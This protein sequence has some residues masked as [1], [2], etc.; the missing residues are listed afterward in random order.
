M[1]K[2]PTIFILIASA[3]HG[4][5]YVKSIIEENLNK[6]AEEIKFAEKAKEI[7]ATSLKT[8]FINDSMSVDEKIE[9]LNDL[10]DNHMKTKV[11]GDENMRKMLQ[12]LLG[13]VIR[14]INHD[15]HALFALKSI[16][17]KI[18]ESNNPLLICT[19]NRYINEQELMYPINLLEKKEDKIDYIRW[20]IDY[21]KTKLDTDKILKKF[22]ELTKPYIKDSK[23][24]SMINKIKMK[25][26]RENDKLTNTTNSKNDYFE[27][28]KGIDFEKIKEMSK[29]E[30]LS[31]GI[32][33]IFRPLLPENDSYNDLS[34]ED[35]I[36]EVS[37]FNK[38][39]IEDI[40]KI[41]DNY[42]M[43][44]LKFNYKNINKYGY[45]RA[46]PNHY[47]ETALNE[48]KPEAFINYPETHEQNIKND[49]KEFFLKPQI[50][51]QSKI[52]NKMQ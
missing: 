9:V 6:K 50:K 20:A 11:L 19:D 4:K 18:T 1:Q 8:E 13:D 34:K 24:Q 39:S 25:F 28:V 23:D 22:D 14:D 26:I 30:S 29:Q 46:N 51:A 32:V 12:V 31:N 16:E 35:L 49:M 37:K 17:E 5:D 44:D 40:Q 15:I 21:N 38:S 47:S 7:I 48:R 33:N 43:F 3:G 36:K 27:F 45:L 2:V 41:A 52:K 10:K 42:E